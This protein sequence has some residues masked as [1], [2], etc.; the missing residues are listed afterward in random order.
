LAFAQ[1]GGMTYP[2]RMEQPAGLVQ[3]AQGEPFVVL[4]D[5]PSSVG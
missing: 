5:A 1:K 3:L 2:P 4:Q